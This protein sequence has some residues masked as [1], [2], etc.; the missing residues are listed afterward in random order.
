MR[1]RILSSRDGHPC[2][3]V[4]DVDAAVGQTW[5][6]VGDAEAL[7]EPPSVQTS[8]HG[9][10]PGVDASASAPRRRRPRPIET[11]MQA[12]AEGR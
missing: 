5:I 6:G 2:G 7:P 11:A 10:A 1:V 9:E 4:V 3:A 12:P 8:A